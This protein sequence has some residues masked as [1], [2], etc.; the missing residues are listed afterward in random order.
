[1]VLGAVALALAPVLQACGP[2]ASTSDPASDNGGGAGAAQ[3]ED[4]TGR[5][6][7]LEAPAQRVVC[8]DGT[9]IDALAELDLPPVAVQHL[10]TAS[11]EHFFGEGE[12][13]EQLDGTYFEPSVEQIIAHG[14]DLVIGS[15]SVHASLGEA[16]GDIPLF[17]QGFDP[18]QAG[19][20]LLRI[21]ALTGRATQAQ[22]AHERWEDV[23]EQYAPG[24]RSTTVLSMYGGATKDI[25]IDA[26][27]ST[28]GALLSRYTAYPWPEA[29]EGESGFLEMSVEDVVEVDPE[30][31]WVLD[32]GFDP[33]A[34][35][36]LD[37][38]D[39]NPLWAGMGAVA[40]E[41]VFAA[42]SSWWGTAAGTRAQ[43]LI[44]DTVLPTV[45]PEEF[46]EPLSGL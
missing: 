31:V 42:D 13:I 26:I 22:E 7:I 8:L 33:D 41:R 46:P 30:Y 35:A 1:V 15:A 44:L 9:A 3:A 27:D 4:W 11:S 38:L 45:Y 5:Q 14:P 18:D 25:G 2:T 36:L 34:P 6:I 23:L 24:E 12:A 29:S 20:N 39:Q 21:G 19:E 40:Q 43:Q 17:L 28:I 16:L 10:A 37:T 32:F